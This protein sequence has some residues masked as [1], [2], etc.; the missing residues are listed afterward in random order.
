MDNATARLRTSLPVYHRVSRVASMAEWSRVLL[1]PVSLR[2]MERIVDPRVVE[3]TEHRPRMDCHVSVIPISQDPSA[4][5]TSVRTG[6]PT[7]LS[8]NRVI[9]RC[10][11]SANSVNFHDAEWRGRII[12]PR[13]PVIV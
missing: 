1:V 4:V 6:P 12:V 9:V 5:I 3:F 10:L 8:L 2:T 13:V 11:M 7:I